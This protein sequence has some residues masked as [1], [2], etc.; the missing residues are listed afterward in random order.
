MRNGPFRCSLCLVIALMLSV[1][2]C[3]EDSSPG[4]SGAGGTPEP[5][6]GNSGDAAG[7]GTAGAAGSGGTVEDAGVTVT[8]EPEESTALF[9]NPGMGW[10][11][12]H[13]FADSD[14]DLDGLPSGSAY[15][16]FTWKALEPTD[17]DIDLDR[18]GKTLDRAREAGQTLMFRVMTAGSDDGYAPEWLESAGCKVFTYE[19]GG[20]M[21]KA[22]DLDDP[23]CW[24][25]FETLMSALGN[26]FGSEPDLQVD[27]GGV[28]LWGEW[29]FSSTTP[30]VPMPSEET[31]RK[32]V[33]LH[34][35]LFPNSPQTA[36]I[37]DVDT[38][39]Y[40]TGKGAGWR[41][42]CL[43]DL[44]FFSDTWNHMDDMYKQHVQQAGAE[45]AWEHGP[46]AWESCGVMQDWV[47]K[48]YDVHDIFAYALEMHGSFLNNKSSTLPAGAQYRAEVEWLIES[49]GYRLLL[50][51]LTH[52]KQVKA[53]DVMPV[54]MTWENKGVA[55][56]YHPFGLQIRLTPPVASGA[57]P[58]TLEIQTDVRTWL[59]GQSHVNE[60][61]PLPASMNAG[62]WGLAVGITG[63]PGIPMLNLAI[64]GRDADGWY[65]VSDVEVL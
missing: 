2:A 21:L 55:P 41:A 26:A 32:V 7:G 24:A 12:F 8:V 65:P 20:A 50:R 23:V 31:C 53:G 6:S 33:D 17:G 15:F 40:A 27:I 29:H 43:G 46:V 58:V 10:Q 22:P 59:P 25:R 16:R 51:S 18:L 36:L 13:S 47:D 1:S 45:S 39:A 56:P 3:S 4:P 38:L 57:D 62:T 60:F 63:T 19:Y 34:F 49:L 5:D 14:P 54:T 28:G 52:P 61:L 42:D 9:A 44:G 30:K 64:E 37:G 48:G 11:T 35:A